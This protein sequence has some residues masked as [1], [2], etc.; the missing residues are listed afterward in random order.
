MSYHHRRSKN[1]FQALFYAIVPFQC[2]VLISPCAQPL[3]EKTMSID[4][5]SFFLFHIT[6]MS[7][8]YHLHTWYS[9]WDKLVPTSRWSLKVIQWSMM[10][11]HI[12]FLH[13]TPYFSSWTPQLECQIYSFD[14]EMHMLLPKG[15]NLMH[16]EKCLII[17]I[18]F[19]LCR[20][21]KLNG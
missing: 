17:T 21:V 9:T 6:S 18:I 20:I 15:F 14:Q 10:H 1:K 12:F 4:V 5:E 11:I 2:Q 13:K 7:K 8:C 19:W 3:D 16:F